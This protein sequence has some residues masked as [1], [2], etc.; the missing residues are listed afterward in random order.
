[1]RG[2]HR[3]GSIS[4]GAEEARAKIADL[5][6]YMA[7]IDHSAKQSAHGLSASSARK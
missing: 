6:R 5:D 7:H 1:M 3:A 2:S 4:H